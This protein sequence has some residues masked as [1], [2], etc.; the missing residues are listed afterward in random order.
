MHSLPLNLLRL[1]G[2]PIVSTT[3]YYRKTTIARMPTLK[4]LDESP[5]FDKEKRLAHAWMAGGLEAEKHERETI[6][7]EEAAERDAHRQ[8]FQ[9]MVQKAKANAKDEAACEVTELREHNIQNE[10]IVNI[11]ENDEEESDNEEESIL[12]IDNIEPSEG[13]CFDIRWNEKD[14]NMLASVEE[15][16]YCNKRDSNALGIDEKTMP[17]YTKLAGEPSSNDKSYHEDCMDII[18]NNSCFQQQAKNQ[19]VDIS[20]NFETVCPSSATP[21]LMNF[22]SFGIHETEQMQVSTVSS[23]DEIKNLHF[24]IDP[25]TSKQ[26][27]ELPEYQEFFGIPEH[28]ENGSAKLSAERLEC[29]L[30]ER[31]FKKGLQERILQRAAVDAQEQL[32][33]CISETDI[34]NL[35]KETGRR[36]IW[37]TN[38]YKDLWT[39]AANID[40]LVIED[41]HESAISENFAPANMELD[42][43]GESVPVCP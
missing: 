29:A 17:L 8:A 12:Q 20:Q 18:R 7:Q 4:Y 15:D 38:M 39:K 10:P 37:G 19:A 27:G 30:K 23:I 35:S 24:P 32:R 11:S 40:H 9:D 16:A 6:L 5:V 31:M 3:R 43:P 33:S 41:T 2:N 14:V 13:K 22:D 34:E 25:M 36:V 26:T 42:M 28:A 21:C 1:S